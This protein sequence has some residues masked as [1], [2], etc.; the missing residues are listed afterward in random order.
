MYAPSAGAAVRSTPASMLLGIGE[1]KKAGS[2]VA[3][4]NGMVVPTGGMVRPIT[5][6]EV[7]V[8]VPWCPSTL[9]CVCAWR[10]ERPVDAA[11][12]GTCRGCCRGF[13]IS[14]CRS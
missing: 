5:E 11:S 12:R 13:R 14:G 4:G 3:A 9:L 8:P 2:L 1:K 10:R 6:G 7:R